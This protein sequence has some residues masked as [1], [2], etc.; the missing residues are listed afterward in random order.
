M[1]SKNL[2]IRVLN[3]GTVNIENFLENGFVS[4]PRVHGHIPHQ[5]SSQECSKS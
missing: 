1:V 3:I 4:G 2:H 5:V